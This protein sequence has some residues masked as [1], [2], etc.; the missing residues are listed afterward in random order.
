MP[1]YTGTRKNVGIANVFVYT[2]HSQ[3]HLLPIRFAINAW[4]Y[5]LDVQ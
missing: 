5:C 2:L 1:N 4:I 3:S